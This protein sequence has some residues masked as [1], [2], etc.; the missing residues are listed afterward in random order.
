MHIRNASDADLDAIIALNALVQRQ[1]AK[2]L[3]DLFK[4]PTEPQQT[5]SAFRGFLADSASLTLLAENEQPAGYLWAQFQNRQ[6][7]WARFAVRLLYIQHI[8]VAPNFRR[9][10]I[11][12]LLLNKAIEIAQ[13]KGVERLELDV[14]SFNGDAK[15]F[16]ERHGFKIFNEKMT[17]RTDGHPSD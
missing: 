4:T 17:L 7:G 11:G 14:W 6:D 12:S 2:A 15:R 16:Y 9:R 13:R 3:P 5:R 1:H 8:V 10:G